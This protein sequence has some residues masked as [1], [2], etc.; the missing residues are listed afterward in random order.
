VKFRAIHAG[1]YAAGFFLSA[2]NKNAEIGKTD[3]S[4]SVFFVRFWDMLRL[5]RPNDTE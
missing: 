2:P 3:E 1:G 5:G 4:K